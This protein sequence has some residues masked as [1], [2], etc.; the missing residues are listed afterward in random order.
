MMAISTD[1]KSKSKTRLISIDVLRGL[2]AL[3]ILLFHARSIL[4]VGLEKT[5]QDNKFNNINVDI[6]LSYLSAPLKFGGLAVT[7]FFVLSGYC[8]HRRGAKLLAENPNAQI[9]WLN[10]I[11]KRIWRIYPTYIVALIVTAL[12][13]WYL[14]TNNS[15]TLD[16]S[17]IL[18]LQNNSLS[19][20]LA[21]L[22][23]LQGI[24]APY[25]GCNG[26]FWTLGIIFH[27][28]L[29]YPLLFIVSRKHGAI[30]A[31]KVSFIVSLIYL[32][33]DSIL[34][35]TNMLPYRGAFNPIFLPYWFT[36]T[37]GFY[38]AEVEIGRAILPKYFRLIFVLSILML[39]LAQLLKI[40]EIILLSSTYVFGIVIYYSVTPK[41]N[42]FY[43]F[44]L[45]KFLAWIGMFSYSIFA[46]HVPLILLFFYYFSPTGKQFTSFYPVLLIS[47]LVVLASYMIFLCVERWTLKPLFWSK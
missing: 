21:S 6:F 42:K 26:V 30:T 1:S 23:S 29:V 40:N 12:V 19:V 10:F 24:I 39:F 8:I 7:L 43:D 16:E 15:F 46:F 11:T 5:W 2:A 45:G 22:L 9:K 32:I 38:I 25:F 34:G 31:L 47:S 18:Q 3:V 35:L 41:G 36:W 44:W 13:D 37:F 20:F 27:F 17:L 33:L 14:L 4:W 28:Y